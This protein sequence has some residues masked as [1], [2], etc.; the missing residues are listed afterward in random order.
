MSNDKILLIGKTVT[1][2][3]IAEDKQ[4]LLFITEDGEFVARCDADCCSYTWIESVELP[5][6]GLP[7]KILEIHDLDMPDLG[8]MPDCEVVAYYGC[9]LI[10]T[11]GDLIIDYRNDSNGYYGGNI[12]WPMPEGEYNYFYGGV[13]DQNVSKEEWIDIEDV[14]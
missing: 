10:T 2:M 14:G 9:K 13:F 1:E 4:A 5:A 6:L 3:K 7:F 11:K 12:V 8:D